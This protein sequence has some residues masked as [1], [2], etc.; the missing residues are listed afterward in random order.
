MSNYQE[1]KASLSTLPHEIFENI[2]YFLLSPNSTKP[3]PKPKKKSND[4]ANDTQNSYAI[5]YRKESK[6]VC[7]EVSVC[8]ELMYVNKRLYDLVSGLIYSHIDL[9]TVY[10]KSKKKSNFI[11]LGAEGNITFVYTNHKSRIPKNALKHVKILSLSSDN[12]NLKKSKTSENKQLPSYLDNMLEISD[13]LSASTTPLL[14]YFKFR[15][16]MDGIKS[17]YMSTID[18]FFLKASQHLNERNQESHRKR[19]EIHICASYELLCSLNMTNQQFSSQELLSDA[20]YLFWSS[21]KYL[22]VIAG[23]ST[24]TL[25]FRYFNMPNLED[26]WVSKSYN[27]NHNVSHLFVEN[28]PIKQWW[29]G[30]T[31]RIDPEVCK[32]IDMS[33]N[34][35]PENISCTTSGLRKLC[36][37]STSSHFENVTSLFLTGNPA[38]IYEREVI[39]LPNLKFF[40]ISTNNTESKEFPEKGISDFLKRNG[41]NL[42]EVTIDTI[43]LQQFTEI[44][45]ALSNIK[46]LKQ[47]TLFGAEFETLFE[48][49]REYKT[50]LSKLDVLKVGLKSSE[51]KTKP[52]IEFAQFLRNQS[53]FLQF[54]LIL[55]NVKMA[56][57]GQSPQTLTELSNNQN[58]LSDCFGEHR[59]RNTDLLSTMR[60][61]VYSIFKTLGRHEPAFV[62]Y[63][64]DLGRVSTEIC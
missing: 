39:K 53:I 51:F 9:D 21:I 19:L 6:T 25:D 26:V 17:Q 48:K 59:K 62:V 12:Y 57:T 16:A 33:T 46:T 22:N 20:K 37:N 54:E 23:V 31:L 41:A 13:L 45:Q 11:T 3:K 49:L 18:E 34:F 35:N 58:P 24:G 8:F 44:F 38:F 52:L 42:T 47:L 36:E 32:R 60:L 5:P 27:N 2:I 40:A 55:D 14:E 61:N 7:L 63:N 15:F 50:L 64:L 56:A 28:M 43:D 10:S 29:Y 30:K 1:F 4:I